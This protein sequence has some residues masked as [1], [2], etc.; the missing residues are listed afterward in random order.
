MDWEWEERIGLV[1]MEGGTFSLA[2][3]AF[4]ETREGAMLDTDSSSRSSLF[5]KELLSS[6]TS[7]DISVSRVYAVESRF[8]FVK[9]W[10]IMAT[11]VI[12]FGGVEMTSSMVDMKLV[13]ELGANVLVEVGVVI[14]GTLR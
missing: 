12:G 8:E 9:F 1:S 13:T 5:M 6:S 11:G 4:T 14:A 7:E 3:G 2:A 10:R